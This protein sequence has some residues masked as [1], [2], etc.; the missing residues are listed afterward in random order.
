MYVVQAM[1]VANVAN[2]ASVLCDGSDEVACFY[3]LDDLFFC[4]CF[5][6]FCICFVLHLFCI[7]V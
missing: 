7:R 2:V 3:H 5:V 6:L 1:S 4:F